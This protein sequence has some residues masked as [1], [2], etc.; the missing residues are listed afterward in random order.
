MGVGDRGEA[1]RLVTGTA[2][3]QSDTTKPACES[4]RWEGAKSNHQGQEDLTPCSPPLGAQKRNR[5][6]RGGVA[7]VMDPPHSPSESLPPRVTQEHETRSSARRSQQPPALAS[8]TPPSSWGRAASRAGSLGP[9][10]KGDKEAKVRPWCQTQC[11][12]TN[13]RRALLYPHFTED[14]SRIRSL[15]QPSCVKPVSQ[16]F[17]IPRAGFLTQGAHHFAPLLNS[18]REGICF[19][20][21][22][23]F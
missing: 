14:D 4:P 11:Q 17:P 15:S 22:G 19:L 3:R 16:P 20:L 9:V 23:P 6:P 8:A 10:A 18:C 7:F 13:R 12:A 21:D 1:S 2:Q 5:G